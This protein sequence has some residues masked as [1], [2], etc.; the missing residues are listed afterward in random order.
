[1]VVHPHHRVL[2]AN[3]AA[4]GWQGGLELDPWVGGMSAHARSRFFQRLSDLGAVDEFEVSWGGG[5]T[6]TW[7]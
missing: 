6:R 5:G 7:A 1:M 4:H 2:H 3:Q